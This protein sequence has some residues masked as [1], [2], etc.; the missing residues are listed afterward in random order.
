MVNPPYFALFVLGGVFSMMGFFVCHE[1]FYLLGSGRRGLEGLD[2]L[3]GFLASGGFWLGAVQFL[4][5][6]F[7]SYWVSFLKRFFNYPLN[8][9]LSLEDMLCQFIDN[10]GNNISSQLSI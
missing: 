9:Y 7:S 6:A 10:F 8:L 4:G 5:T 2:D 3:I 1:Q